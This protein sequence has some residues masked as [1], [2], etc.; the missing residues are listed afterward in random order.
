MITPV[1]HQFTP[2]FSEGL[3][4]QGVPPH[5]ISPSSPFQKRIPGL[6]IRIQCDIVTG[7]KKIFFV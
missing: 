2:N 4:L 5:L 1:Y 6:E 7:G 3:F